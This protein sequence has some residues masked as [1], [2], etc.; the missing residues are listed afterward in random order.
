MSKNQK[1]SDNSAMKSKDQENN[2]FDLNTK[3]LH[4]KGLSLVQRIKK[5]LRM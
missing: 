3:S 5:L 1:F 4:T 2:F